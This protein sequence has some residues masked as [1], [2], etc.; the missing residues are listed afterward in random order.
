MSDMFT[1]NACE[2]LRDHNFKLYKKCCKTTVDRMISVW[3]NLPMILGMF[4]PSMRV[5]T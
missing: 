2:H 5:K 4:L 3:N 1:L